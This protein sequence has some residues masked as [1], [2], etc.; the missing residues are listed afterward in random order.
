MLAEA[1]TSTKSDVEVA[2]RRE[3]AVKEPNPVPP[4]DS[5]N[6]PD[7][8]GVKV[9]EEPEE[10][11]VSPKLV[12]ELV[13]NVWLAP[14]R[15]FKEVMPEPADADQET[16]RGAVE[17]AV[18]VYP[19]V[20]VARVLKTEPSPTNNLPLDGVVE[21]PVPPKSVPMAEPF[22]TPEMTVPSR[23]ILS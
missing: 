21:V 20:L 11:M 22:H 7:Q 23:V 17:L 16:P 4:L 1:V 15:P 13:A 5:A 6:V 14:E 18:K 8:I 12:S 10:P 19:S 2:K 3:L 9:C